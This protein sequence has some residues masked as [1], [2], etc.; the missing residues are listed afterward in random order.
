[1]N[2]EAQDLEPLL[3]AKHSFLAR[4]LPLYSYLLV[5][6]VTLAALVP[7]SG[8]AFHIDD[9]L[10]LF[11]A[12]QIVK[13]AL[14]P[15]GFQL[16]WKTT[17]QPMSRVTE[18]PPLA[19]YYA[20]LV[21]RLAGWQAGPSRRCIWGFSFRRWRFCWGHIVWPGGVLNFLCSPLWSRC[22]R[23]VFWFQRPASCATP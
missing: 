1:M 3:P 10:F 15:D 2:E 5:A 22:F 16:V 19:C 14:D 4:W 12:K 20:A 18:N 6:G 8:K 9:T 23:R 21:G 17:L 7:F 13:P 11:A